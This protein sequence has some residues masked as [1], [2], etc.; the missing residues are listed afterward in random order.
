MTFDVGP[1]LEALFNF[2]ELPYNS[3]YTVRVMDL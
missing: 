1:V 2:A 3:S